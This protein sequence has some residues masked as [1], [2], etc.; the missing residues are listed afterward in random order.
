MKLFNF[1]KGSARLYKHFNFLSVSPLI[2][3]A[4]NL[5]RALLFQC[6]LHIYIVYAHTI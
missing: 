2:E 1:T 4:N 6:S 3:Y 5:S